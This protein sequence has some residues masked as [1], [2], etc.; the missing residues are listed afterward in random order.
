MSKEIVIERPR[1]LRVVAG[2]RLK[3]IPAAMFVSKTV[4]REG[5]LDTEE[6]RFVSEQNP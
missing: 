5:E 6:S 4:R 1:E 3:G 2:R